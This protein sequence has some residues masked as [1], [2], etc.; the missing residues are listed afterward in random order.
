MKCR[1][2]NG[3]RAA[4]T[5]CTYNR[6]GTLIA[7]ACNDG[8]VQM[9]DHRKMFVSYSSCVIQLCTVQKPFLFR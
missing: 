4:P 9:W 7:S 1:S 8:S 6:D 5:S 3:L 2:Q